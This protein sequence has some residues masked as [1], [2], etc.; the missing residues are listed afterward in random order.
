[1]NSRM[2]IKICG[3]TTEAGVEAA[4]RAQ[5]DA[6]GFVFAASKRRVTAQRAAELARN[7]PP[8]IARVAVFL[9][10]RQHE[11]DEVCDVLAPD[12]VQTD[13]EDL[14]TLRIPE[15]VRVNAVVRAGRVPATLPRRIVFEGPVSGTGETTDWTEAE[16]LAR[17]TQLILAGGLNPDN[18]AA[19]IRSVHPFG[20]DVSSGV[21][22][23]PGIKDPALILRFVSA[24]REAQDVLVV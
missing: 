3:L 9:H 10:P 12:Y 1:M 21:E 2:W 7:V 14:A 18:V 17:R 24:A 20:V 15:N 4:V 16:R 23:S 8:A 11:I 6:I 22:A 5:V 19:A 13:F